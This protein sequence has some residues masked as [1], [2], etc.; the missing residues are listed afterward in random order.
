[1][2]GSLIV[3]DYYT[4]T[5]QYANTCINKDKPMMHCNGKCQMMKKIQTEEKKDQENPE[6]RGENKNEITLSSRSCF[7]SIST[8]PIRTAKIPKTTS[9]IVGH[10]LDRSLDIFHPPQEC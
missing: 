9:Y 1:M 8:F 2:D 3:L 5:S 10:I 7:L 6:R 4:H